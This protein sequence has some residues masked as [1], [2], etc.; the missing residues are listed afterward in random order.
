MGIS[1]LKELILRVVVGLI[2]VVFDVVELVRTGFFPAGDPI[3][4]LDKECIFFQHFHWILFGAVNGP[5]ICLWVDPL[6]RF[7]LEEGSISGKTFC[8][9]HSIILINS[10]INIF[11]YHHSSTFFIAW[12]SMTVPSLATTFLK[13]FGGRV[14]SMPSVKITLLDEM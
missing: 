13:Y 2:V 4:A 14:P 10:Y 9:P 7:P 3:E 11:P 1:R 6:L 8:F 12:S 5:L